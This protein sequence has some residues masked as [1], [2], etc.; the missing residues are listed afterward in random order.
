[1]ARSKTAVATRRPTIP[2]WWDFDEDGKLGRGRVRARRHA[3]TPQNGRGRSSCSTSTTSSG[4]S[5]C[6]TTCCATSS[7]ARCTVAPTR[8]ST[9]GETVRI[10]QLEPRES[11]SNA[12][13]SYTDYR[14]EF[15]DGPESTQADIFGAPPRARRAAAGGRGAATGGGVPDDDIPFSVS[16]V[17]GVRGSSPRTPRCSRC[18]AG[19]SRT[20]TGLSQSM[21]PTRTGGSTGVAGRACPLVRDAVRRL[22]ACRLARPAQLGARRHARRAVAPDRA[23]AGAHSGQQAP[24]PRQGAACVEKELYAGLLASGVDDAPP[25]ISSGSTRRRPGRELNDDDIQGTS[26]GPCDCASPNAA[27]RTR[28]RPSH[29]PTPLHRDRAVR[30]APRPLPAR[31]RRV[32]GAP[33]ARAKWTGMPA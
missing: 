19:V 9:G 33:R 1:M 25:G 20:A 12:G 6:T 30:A 26:R 31:P 32:T 8:R 27:S 11:K 13:R 3:A 22:V 14:V 2:T 5:G 15:P 4:R 16:A 7:R 18:L 28:Q 10:W 17:E 23:R 24:T 29:P 21:G